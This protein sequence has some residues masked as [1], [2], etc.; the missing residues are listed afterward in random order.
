MDV[1]RDIGQGFAHGEKVE[2]E[3]D[4]LISRRRERPGVQ[5]RT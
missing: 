4:I 5:R 1:A 3:L 2:G